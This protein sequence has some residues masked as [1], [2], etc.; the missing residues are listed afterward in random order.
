MKD[1]SSLSTPNQASMLVRRRKPLMSAAFIGLT[2][3]SVSVVAQATDADQQNKPAFMLSVVNH[4]EGSNRSDNMSEPKRQDNRRTDVSITKQMQVG[5]RTVN[6]DV[7]EVVKVKVSDAV[8]RSIRLKDGGVIWVSKDPASLTPVLNVTAPQTI[9]MRSGEFETPMSFEINTNYAAF[10]DKWELQVFHSNDEQQKKP[11]ATFMGRSLENGRTLKWDGSNAKGKKLKAGD[12][13]SYILKVEDKEG[14]IDKTG[15]REISLVGP[16]RN[17]Q[18]SE[19]SKQLSRFENNIQLQTIP[20]RGS[21]VRIFGRDIPTGNSITIDDENISLV[22]NKFVLEKLLP[23][24]KH[25][26]GVGI[27]DN[28]QETYQKSLNVNLKSDYMFMV[29]LADI[30]AG[31]G[32]V[33]ANL[34]TL[35]DGESISMVTCLLMVDQLFTL[36]VKLKGNIQ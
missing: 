1:K 24:G 6:E 10:I 19:G 30:T 32:K 18:E 27:T 33:S 20:I 9:N 29:G 35:G 12:Q 36:K 11:L 2:L 13:L 28:N 23:E 34:E 26:F 16:N 14:H 31:K 8:Q 25:N 7:S 4:G 17:I 15:L 3:C 21:R 5:T 22:D